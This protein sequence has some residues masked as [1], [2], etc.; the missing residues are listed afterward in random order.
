MSQKYKNPRLAVLASGRGSNFEAIQKAIIRGDL[1]AKVVVI[2]SDHADAGALELARHYKIPAISVAKETKET[3]DQKILQIIKQHQADVVV[4]AGYNKLIREPVLS[5]Y[6]DRII[7]IH[8]APLPEFGGKGLH[9]EAAH[10]AVLDSGRA[11]SGPTVHLV[12]A[13]YDKG[14]ILAH[15]PVPVKPGDA[16]ETLA[17]RVLPFEHDLYWRII[18]KEFCK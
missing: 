12:N 16:P 11:T 4:L 8:P 14:K 17:A 1:P 7:N 3:R 13:E 6:A 18:K 2:I 10:Q 15:V 9:Q 5:A